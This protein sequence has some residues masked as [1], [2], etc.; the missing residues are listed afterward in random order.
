MIKDVVIIVI[1]I[2][3]LC[4]QPGFVSVPAAATIVA[5]VIGSETLWKMH[6]LDTNQVQY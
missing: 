1:T 6:Q 3:K 2:V 4:H 5:Q